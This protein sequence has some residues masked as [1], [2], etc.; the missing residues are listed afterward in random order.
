MDNNSYQKLKK[1][2]I[3][4]SKQFLLNDKKKNELNVIFENIIRSKDNNNFI[5]IK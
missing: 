2:E 5:Y 1:N 3:N 4:Y